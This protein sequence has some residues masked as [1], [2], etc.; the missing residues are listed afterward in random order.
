MIAGH[1]NSLPA[2]RDVE[3]AGGTLLVSYSGGGSTLGNLCLTNFKS[4]PN[5]YINTAV[6]PETYKFNDS[7]IDLGT[8]RTA[9]LKFS[10]ATNWITNQSED[11]FDVV[12]YGRN[13]YLK[14]ANS[15]V[16]GSLLITDTNGVSLDRIVC[17]EDINLTAQITPEGRIYFI[18]PSN[19][20]YST[21]TLNGTAGTAVPSLVPTVT[22]TGITFSVNPALPSGLSIH[23]TTGVLSG[24]PWV[25]SEPTLYTVTAR[26]AVGGTS[27][28]LTITVALDPAEDEDGDGLTNGTEISGGTNPYQK[29]SDGDGV[30]DP[31]EIADGTNQND[32]SSYNNLNKGLVAYY[33]FNGNVND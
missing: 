20:S 15:T 13:Q 16:G 25:G 8:N 18:S 9:T 29:D 23:P 11:P 1:P 24:V 2:T 6:V 22:G 5:R 3:M 7:I 10:S 27:T 14:V 31:V 28:T 32:A 12:T 30:T 17:A 33:P 19:L 21:S 4:S 26:N